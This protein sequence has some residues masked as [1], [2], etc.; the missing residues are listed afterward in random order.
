MQC[1][2]AAFRVRFRLPRP[3]ARSFESV[4]LS[5][6]RDDV[7]ARIIWCANVTI[8]FLAT[9]RQAN[10]LAVNINLPANPPSIHDFKLD[11]MEYSFIKEMD[12]GVSPSLTR[13][14]CIYTDKHQYFTP[15]ELLEVL[16]DEVFLA[17]YRIVVV[18]QDGFR[19]LPGPRIE[20]SVLNPHHERVLALFP[21][22]TVLLLDGLTDRFLSLSPLLIWR[23]G[24]SNP[25]GRLFVLR[26]REKDRGHYIEEGVPGSRGLVE[27]I[28][29][30]PFMG[31]LE[32]GE[33]V[34]KKLHF[35][36]VRFP[37]G[38]CTGAGRRIFGF[39][40]RGGMSDIYVACSE[41]DGKTSILKTFENGSAFLDEN[42]WRFINEERFSRS[43]EHDQVI[44]PV[45]II[46]GSFGLVYELAY[47]RRG[48]IQDLIDY[49]GVLSPRVVVNI[50]D[51]LLDVLAA[52][53]SA[54]IVHNDIKPDNVLFDDYGKISLIDFGIA[55]NIS[56]SG[57]G[58][59]PGAPAGS[60]GYIAPEL[61]LGAS[62]SPQS[63]LFSVG[64][65]FARMVSGVMVRNYG[66]VRAAGSISRRYY[67]FLEKCIHADPRRRF[68]DAGE[69]RRCLNEMRLPLERAITL[70][71]E[72]TLITNFNDLSP[73]PGL[74][75]FISFCMNN[76]DRIFIYTMLDRVR[77]AKVFEVLAESGHVPGLFCD[78]YEYVD[79][80]LG[81]DGS[82][83]DLRRCLFP[84]ENNAIVDDM[85]SMIP[86]DQVHRL[87]KVPDYNEPIPFDG[88]LSIAKSAIEKKFNLV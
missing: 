41:Q 37:D 26:G 87:I 2:E 78:V 38:Y 36:A 86:E 48:S 11:C 31:S 77:A 4:V 5:E 59:R 72:G 28:Q 17:D 35:P 84:L 54:G 19:V 33:S 1:E 81:L 27:L 46:V 64:V 71:I 73:R 57:S 45:R 53:H 40:W 9:I 21:P 82:L 29:G 61:I 42:Y 70:D 76:F 55:F 43:I 50:T 44:K 66:E 24:A 15:G 80:S 7:N 32:V 60:E 58:M 85:A 65:L 62:P 13:L 39:V 49:N 69:A 8:R 75:D 16:G 83:K 52:V 10:Y 14:A 63:D 25:F 56:E 30:Y 18:E 88:G 47:V 20:Y 79:W 74:Y 6:N 22:G 68:S 23:R 34:L 12:C 67:I 51:Q 3:I